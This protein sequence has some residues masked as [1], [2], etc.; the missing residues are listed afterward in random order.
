MGKHER[1]PI[2]KAEKII[3]KILNSKNINFNDKKN[4]WFEHAFAIAQKIRKDFPKIISAHHLGNTYDNTGD[5]LV[6]SNRNKFFVEIKMSDTK[7]GI[8]TKANISQNSLT[9]NNLFVENVKSWSEFRLNKKHEEWVDSYLNL[10]LKY[11]ERILKITNFSLQREEKGRYLRS[12]K[13]KR[14]KM[15]VEILDKI[16]ERDR[17]EKIEYLNYLKEQEQQ[18]EMIKRFFVLIMLGIH[19]GELLNSLIKNNNFFQEVENILIYYSNIVKN[20]IIVRRENV[21]DRVKKTIDKFSDFKIIFPKNASNCKIVGIKNNE[22]YPL[23][24]IVF[25]WK[26]IAQGIKTPCLNIFDL[27]IK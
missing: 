21:G 8:G 24:Q 20:K 25:H 16:R 10:F 18:S 13:K 22:E 6:V 19:K 9:D 17:K 12:L 2:E 15:A 23:L 3:V 1:R 27:N 26:N 11:P 14:T 7:F 5:I 4:R